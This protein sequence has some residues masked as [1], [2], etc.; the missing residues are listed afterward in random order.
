MLTIWVWPG[1]TAACACMC[2]D[3]HV[4]IMHGHKERVHFKQCI[5]NSAFVH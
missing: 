4:G 5:T 1:G 3:M 2:V